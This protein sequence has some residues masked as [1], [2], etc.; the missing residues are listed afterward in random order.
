MTMLEFTVANQKSRLKIIPYVG[1]KSGFA[2]IF[3]ELIPPKYGSKIYDIFGGGGGF[4]FYACKRFGSENIVYNDHNPVIINLMKHLKDNPKELYCE[5]QRHY[6]RS[7]ETYY[8]DMREKNLDKG[9]IGAGRFFYLSKNA[10]SGKIRFN[11][12]N[13]FNTPMRKNSKCPQI[14][15][16]TILELSRIIKQLVIK[17]K[18]YTDYA[19]IEKSFIY[20]DP[21]YMNNPNG[22]YNAIVSLDDFV[23]FVKKVQDKN[24]IMISEQNDR[25]Q[26]KL[27][28]QYRVFPIT[29]RRS[30]QYNTQNNSKEIIAVNYKISNFN[31]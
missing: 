28:K 24:K 25:V 21:P 14:D 12:Q 4:T 13:K 1:C 22:H 20:L 30:L 2:H 26:L 8:L 31:T 9:V 10:F 15:K 6:K 18:D 3:D 29:L 11:S 19:D 7:D 5:Y 23:K 16:D 17:N 27:S